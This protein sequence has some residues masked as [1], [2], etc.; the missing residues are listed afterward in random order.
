LNNYIKSGAK[1]SQRCRRWDQ[2]CRRV[3]RSHG[4][5]RASIAEELR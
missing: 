4:D 5:W 1:A 2:R 3:S